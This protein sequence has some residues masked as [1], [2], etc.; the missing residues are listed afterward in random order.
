M[1]KGDASDPKGLIHEAYRIDGITDA[2]CRSIFLDWAL[3]L[4]DGADVQQAILALLG[5]YGA[6]N[7]DHP[8]TGVLREGQTGAARPQRRGGWRART[9]SDQT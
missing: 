1:R 7:A 2:E 6:E 8:M 9:R 3:S 4:A 5:S